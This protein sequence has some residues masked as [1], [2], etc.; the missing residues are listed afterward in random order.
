MMD[1]GDFVMKGSAVKNFA[2][3]I[4]W[5]EDFMS[6]MAEDLKKKLAPEPVKKKKMRHK[7][8]KL[9]DIKK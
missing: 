9:K 7:K 2:A 8:V 6:K 5:Q 3:L 1:G 4:L